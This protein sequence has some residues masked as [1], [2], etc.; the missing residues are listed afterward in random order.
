MNFNY[1]ALYEV[2]PLVRELEGIIGAFD[3]EV[4]STIGPRWDRNN[5]YYTANVSGD[6]LQMDGEQGELVSVR[7]NQ[8]RAILREVFSVITRTNLNYRPQAKVMDGRTLADMRLV[9]GL[10]A[11][12]LDNGK[13]QRKADT[14]LEKVLVNGQAYIQARWREDRGTPTERDELGNIVYSGAN[15]FVVYHPRNVIF[16]TTIEDFDDQPWVI[17]RSKINRYAM[18]AMYP[19]LKSEI[20]SLPPAYERNDKKRPYRQDQIY[21]YE[22]YHIDDPSC[23]GGRYTAFSDARTIYIDKENPYGRL[24]VYECKPEPIEE[25]PWGATPCDDLCPMQKIY[26]VCWSTILSNIADY[27]VGAMLNPSG[28]GLSSSMLMGK[29]FINYLPQSATGGGK[30]EPLEF[31]RTP[32]EVFQF[33]NVIESTMMQLGHINATLRGTPPP[34][35][36]SGTMAATLS[37]NAIEFIQPTSKAFFRTMEDVMMQ[38]ISNYQ[39]FA[40]VP[41]LISIAGKNNTAEAKKFVGKDIPILSR[42][43]IEQQSALAA[44]AT[45]VGDMAEKLLKNGLIKN[46]AE[47]IEFINTGR[48]ETMTQGETSQFENAN[49]ENDMLR[50]GKKVTASVSD[51]VPHHVLKHLIIWNDP[52][53]RALADN[54]TDQSSEAMKARAVLTNTMEHINEHFDNY[55][56]KADPLMLA[57]LA[58]GQLPPPQPAQPSPGA[59]PQGAPMPPQQGGQ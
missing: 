1:W 26:D 59:P 37:A 40:T 13:G 18:M 23:E 39:E 12:L 47:F 17:L 10:I 29:R 53:L 35:V 33:H 56:N 16:D 25:S 20:A 36:T 32:P 2:V 7:A 58:T 19:H 50:E 31:P 52:E 11:E 28:N 43:R 55:Q 51:Y 34:N 44:T 21:T 3:N 15:E 48:I 41:Q 45:G 9:E 49:V 5:E 6:V 54:Q 42:V 38:A 14:L 46:P 57:L 22:F 30:P 24:N 8:L 4:K 27:G